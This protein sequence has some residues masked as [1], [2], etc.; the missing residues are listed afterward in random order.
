M[1]ARCHE[2]PPNSDST[3]KTD[4]KKKGGEKMGRERGLGELEGSKLQYKMQQD[5]AKFFLF[6]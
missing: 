3:L 5:K 1:Y 2:F 6:S 4:G